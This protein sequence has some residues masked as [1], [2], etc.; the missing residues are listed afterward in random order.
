MGSKPR[1]LTGLVAPFGKPGRTSAGNLQID[2]RSLTWSAPERV[3]LLV[4]HDPN[5]AIG[6]ATELTHTEQGLQGTFVVDD[7]AEAT[8][9]L[10][11][12]MRMVRD[13]LSFGA[14]LSPETSV[15][16]AKHP[17]LASGTLARGTLREV[18]LVAVPAFDDA[19]VTDVDADLDQ[20]AAA[21]AATPTTGGTKMPSNIVTAAAGQLTTAAAPTGLTLAAGALAGAQLEDA[22]TAASEQ[23][24]EQATTA[25][26]QLEDGA[27]TAASEQTQASAPQATPAPRPQATAGAVLTAHAGATYTFDGTGE[28]S[29]V[30]DVFA[31]AQGDLDAAGRLHVFQRSMQDQGSRQQDAVASLMGRVLADGRLASAAV[32]VRDAT[33]DHLRP[34]QYR[35]D[36]VLRA[37]DQGR[38]LVS[39]VRQLPLAGPDPFRL[40][41][42]GEFDAVGD[43]TEGTAHV[44]EGTMQDVGAQVVVPTAVSGAYRLSRELAESS[45]ALA[46]DGIV[47]AEMVKDYR[48]RSEAR[49]VATLETAKPAVDAT[50]TGPAG[51]LAQLVTFYG[52]RKA[53]PTVAAFGSTAYT[54]AAT[55]VASDGRPV[56]PYLGPTNAA[57]TSE[58]G[59]TALSLQGVAGVPAWSASASNV[60]LLHGPDVAVFESAPRLFRF[61]ETEGPGIIKLAIWGYQAAHIYRVQGV[62]RLTYAK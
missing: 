3:K 44:A 62:R 50:A 45:S 31:A 7:S 60:W 54:D 12:A 23:T 25:G 30:R 59:F 27:T 22:T 33:T 1:T 40:P 24:G 17:A 51:L 26:A 49:L 21:A 58:A 4:E 46:W 43:H 36:Q 42:L 34:M 57:G 37:I 10:A 48:D 9:A 35:N 6:Y 20:T 32:E 14:E 28:H 41:T 11:S 61:E 15:A 18:S 29:M 55:A 53:A 8:A 52:A 13:G 19:R 2:A 39:R 16:V 47:L 5:R 38:P 56:F